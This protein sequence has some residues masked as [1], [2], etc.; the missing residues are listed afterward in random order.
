VI[1]ALAGDWYYPFVYFMFATGTRTGE[2]RA[3]RWG[4]VNLACGTITI[5][6]SLD[7]YGKHKPT[8]TGTVRTIGLT[9]NLVAL[10]QGIRQGELVF[11]TPN[12]SPIHDGNFRK[13]VW[14]P[15]LERLGIPYRK[16]YTT[17]ATA[18]SN[19]LEAGL[20]PLTVSSITGHSLE[21]MY[22]HYAASVKPP[23]L[24]DFLKT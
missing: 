16:P 18:V 24:V 14:K 21:V 17:R 19:L 8:K 11:T 22:T 10:L 3:L 13:R 9:Q 6:E 4:N 23:Q 2:A 15:L 1:D 5:C 20:S 12:G 7:R